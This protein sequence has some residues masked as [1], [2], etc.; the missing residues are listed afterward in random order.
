MID[1]ECILNFGEKLLYSNKNWTALPISAQ[2][3][4]SVRTYAIAQMNARNPST[5]E[6]L[7]EIFIKE[8]NSTVLGSTEDL[9]EDIQEIKEK[10]MDYW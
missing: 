2:A 4:T 8:D 1:Q 5:H 6:K 9:I 10:K 3:T 7:V